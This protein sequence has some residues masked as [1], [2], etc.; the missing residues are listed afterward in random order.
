[1]VTMSHTW[2]CGDF[3]LEMDSIGRR[4]VEAAN[5]A[6][7]RRT[8]VRLR[9]E[10][11]SCNTDVGQRWWGRVCPLFGMVALNGNMVVA[12]CIAS[13]RIFCRFAARESIE[14]LPP[15]MGSV[16]SLVLEGLVGPC[17]L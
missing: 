6:R 1:M 10:W 9:M 2:W 3:I 8:L 14:S 17:R 11:T 5:A 13:S 12:M 15:S 4:D 16:G 7:R